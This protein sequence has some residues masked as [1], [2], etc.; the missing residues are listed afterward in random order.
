[1]RSYIE[2]ASTVPS[3]SKNSKANSQK[4]SHFSERGKKIDF[5]KRNILEKKLAGIF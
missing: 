4:M 3:S 2:A 1:M 5:E